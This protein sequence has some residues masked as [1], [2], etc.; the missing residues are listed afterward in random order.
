MKCVPLTQGKVALVDDEDFERVSKHKWQFLNFRKTGKGYATRSVWE[1]ERRVT[2]FMHVFILGKQDGT[3]VDHRDQDKLNN[4]R[5]N[6]RRCTNVQNGQNR[7]IQNHSTAFK[8]V[9]FLRATGKFQCHINVNKKQ[10]YLGSFDDPI[11]AALSYDKAALKH[12]G[13][14]SRLNFQPGVDVEI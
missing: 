5:S 12:F 13:E 4:Q 14:F 11:E 8:G 3:Q 10:N 1:G 2:Q 6:L 9:H 7:K